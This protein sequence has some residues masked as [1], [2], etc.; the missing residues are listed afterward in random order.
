MNHDDTETGGVKHRDRVAGILTIN[1]RFQLGR[2]VITPNAMETLTPDD[3]QEGLQRHVSGD[4]GRVCIED[5]LEN[6]LSL[7][8]GFR[9]L[10]AYDARNGKRF[11]IITE[12][13]RSVTTVLLP[14]D[15]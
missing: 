11:W 8:D 14:A 3:V 10:S 4:W 7:R 2:L 5:R 15:Y 1:P 9:L 6:D 12:W 13:D